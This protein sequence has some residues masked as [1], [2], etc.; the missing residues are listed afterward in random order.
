MY[1]AV[2]PNRHSPPAI[3]LR[4]SFREQGKVH[5]RTIANLSHWPPA[6]M[7]P[8]KLGHQRRFAG[9]RLAGDQHE[10]ACLRRAFELL[11]KRRELGRTLHEPHRSLR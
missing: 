2:V 4:E 10:L 1:V 9:P 5:N 3:L 8:A 7:L 11:R 6:Q